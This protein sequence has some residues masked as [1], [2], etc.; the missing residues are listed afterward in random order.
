MQEL[1]N[2]KILIVDDEAALLKMIE[3]V[4]FSEGFYSLYTAQD[5]KKALEIV[6]SQPIALFLLDI[7]LPD[8][9]G[10]MLYRELRHYSQAPVMFLTARGEAD[11]RIRGLDLGADDYIVKPFLPRELVLRIKALLRRTYGTEAKE[12][13]FSIG[14]R[15][16]D[17]EKAAVITPEKET[18]LTAKELIL[19]KKLWE[20]RNRIVTNDALC[21]AAWGEDYYGH[22]N[23][24]MVHIRHLR[25]KLEAN[26]SKPQYLIT[27]KGLG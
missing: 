8:G 25:Q 9:N 1:L 5:C 26:P 27:V 17:F 19:I 11:D 15:K 20:N 10:F 3:D 14:T 13:G 6:Q 23:N 7:N 2:K 16:I 21:M 24:L 18:P 12:T 4:L 22:E